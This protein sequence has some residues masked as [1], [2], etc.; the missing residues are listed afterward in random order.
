MNWQAVGAL[1]AIGILAVMVADH[2]R[3]NQVSRAQSA[4]RAIERMEPAGSGPMTLE[5]RPGII[6][7][8]SRLPSTNGVPS[9]ILKDV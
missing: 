5:A 1:A 6:P 8:P 3:N 2:R 4:T 9:V 7:H